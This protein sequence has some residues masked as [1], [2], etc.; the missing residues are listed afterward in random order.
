[1]GLIPLALP[2]AEISGNVATVRMA[3]ASLV[4]PYLNCMMEV[5]HMNWGPDDAQR[6][7]SHL[8][9]NLEKAYPG[10][11]WEAS[12]AHGEDGLVCISDS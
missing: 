11:G 8:I 5:L 7:C 3:T 9:H 6:I 12:D 10:R 4:P 2:P 1:M